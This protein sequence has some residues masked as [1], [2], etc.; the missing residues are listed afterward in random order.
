[1]NNFMLGGEL[2]LTAPLAPKKAHYQWGQVY[3]LIQD[4]WCNNNK[5]KPRQNFIVLYMGILQKVPF[6][7]W[8][9]D[10]NSKGVGEIYGPF[11]DTWLRPL[12]IS[13]ILGSREWVGP[14]ASPP[15]GWLI[16]EIFN[17]SFT[18]N[19]RRLGARL[20]PDVTWLPSKELHHLIPGICSLGVIYLEGLAEI[21]RIHCHCLASTHISVVSEFWHQL[22][23]LH[24]LHRSCMPVPFWSEKMTVIPNFH[25]RHGSIN[26]SD[27]V[28]DGITN[29]VFQWPISHSYKNTTLASIKQRWIMLRLWYK[30]KGRI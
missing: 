24:S 2:N 20:I 9:R 21:A 11:P 15:M 29:A 30:R 23:G 13:R 8:D 4:N 18:N 26:H 22:Q 1:M 16:L 6:T 25:Q 10:E 7:V 19:L 17:L 12:W 28:Q 14:S 27:C 3:D 5:W